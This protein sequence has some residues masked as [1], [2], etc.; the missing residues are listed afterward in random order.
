VAQSTCDDTFVAATPDCPEL[1][2]VPLTALQSASGIAVDLYV[3]WDSAAAPVL[4]REHHLPAGPEEFERLAAQGIHTVY[5]PADGVDEYHRYLRRNLPT[6]LHDASLPPERRYEF[7]SET[8]RGLLQEA[9]RHKSTDTVVNTAG[10]LAEQMAGMLAGSQII[11]LDLFRVLRHDYHTFTHSFNVASFALALAKALGISDEEELGKV[12]LAGLLHDLGKLNVPH[13]ILNKRGPL[14]HA[15]RAVVQRHPYDG[16][17]Q[18]C[19]RDDLTWGQL[20]MVYQHHERIDGRGYPARIGGDE[21]HHLARLCAVVDVFEAISSVRP[22]R[23]ALP[24]PQ[25]L[26]F[27]NKQAGTHLDEE[28]VRCWTA[29]MTP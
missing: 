6:I 28:M 17:V 3:K 21:I 22:Y 25:A 8:G 1:I 18:L 7:L 26:E 11:S 29:V 4:Y 12:A 9:F 27:I 14:T 20:M 13:A 15:E 16:F 5:I 23:R 2:P 10:Q 24:V 19:H